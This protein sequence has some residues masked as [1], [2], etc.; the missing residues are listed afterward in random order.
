M[1]ELRPGSKVHVTM[2]VVSVD[3]DGVECRWVDSNNQ[4]QS[5]VFSPDVL[6]PEPVR[7]TRSEE[8]QAPSTVER[9]SR[10][11]GERS[12]SRR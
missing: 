10:F 4:P 8:P 1:T 6:N 7:P 3:A 9:A 12:R 2:T 5:A 11:F